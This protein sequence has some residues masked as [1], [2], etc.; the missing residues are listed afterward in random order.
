MNLRDLSKMLGA[1]VRNSFGA[2][3]DDTRAHLEMFSKGTVVG[4]V[5]A[6]VQTPEHTDH[7]PS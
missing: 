6:K 4:S 3:I 7:K 5:G 1:A 2:L